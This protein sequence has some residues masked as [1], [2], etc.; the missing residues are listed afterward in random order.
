M[1]KIHRRIG[2]L[3]HFL[4]MRV[5]YTST[6]SSSFPEPIHEELNFFFLIFASS[7]YHPVEHLSLP[8]CHDAQFTVSLP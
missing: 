6:K 1:T 2:H 3:P 7:N 8:S 4:I 5:Y